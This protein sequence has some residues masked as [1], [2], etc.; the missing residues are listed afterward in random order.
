V[1]DAD[2]YGVI[3]WDHMPMPESFQTGVI[4]DIFIEDSAANEISI[5]SDSVQLIQGR[6]Y[7]WALWTYSK[8]KPID[9]MPR[10]NVPSMQ[11][12]F[13]VYCPDMT[14]VETPFPP[15][16]P[17]R[18]NLSQNYPNPFNLHTA[19]RYSIPAGMDERVVLKI[20]NVLGQQIC[21]LVDET[22][23][24]GTYTVRW[25]GDDSHGL[26]VPSG[27]YI[28]TLEIGEKREIKIMTLMQ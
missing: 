14:N 28:Y 6:T 23:S 22:E 15:P 27:L 25:D 10:F 18:L 1:L 5:P 16:T 3:V 13:F 8:A 12:G 4:W 9:G 19:I 26:P 21:V 24:T 20:C 7:Y 2:G 17:A 11:W